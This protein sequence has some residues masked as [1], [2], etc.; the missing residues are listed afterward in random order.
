MMT[1]LRQ[2]MLEELQ[3][4]NYCTGT[5]RLY[6]RHVAAFAQHFHR[7]PDQ[8][9]AEDIRRYDYAQ[10]P[11]RKC[12]LDISTQMHIEAL[13]CTSVIL[14]S[15]TPRCEGLRTSGPP[16]SSHLAVR[17]PSPSSRA[18]AMRLNLVPTPNTSSI[19]AP[20][21]QPRTVESRVVFIGRQLVTGV[22]SPRDSRG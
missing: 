22:F 15:V 8:L 19:D 16:K 12:N 3:Q 18:A 9:G 7:S 14:V 5:I 4:R 10:N 21:R 11:S 13:S 17:N 2:R 6:L 20:P 1:Q